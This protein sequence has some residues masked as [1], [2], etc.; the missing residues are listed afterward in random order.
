M[1][2]VIQQ[3]D[4]RFEKAV[5]ARRAIEIDWLLDIA[6]YS[7]KQYTEWD[8]KKGLQEIP[9]RK[10]REN[11]PRPV[12]NRLYSLVMDVYAAA[13][14]HEPEVEVLPQNSDAMNVADAKVQQAFLDHLTGPTQ[15]NWPTRRDRA[16][17]WVALL[18]EG[19]L[20]WTFD[21]DLKRPT[22]Q[23]CSPLE[24]YTD[25]AE[26]Y[27]DSRWIIH[28]RSMD[29]EDVYEVYG[30]DLPPDALGTSATHNAILREVG[31]DTSTPQVLVKE[32]WELP[33][34]RYANGRFCV[35]AGG[36]MLDA[37]GFPYDHKLLPFTQI[38]HSPIPGTARYHSGT[39]IARPIQMELNQYHAQKITSRQKFANFKWFID[40][41]QAESMGG[42]LPDDSE[43]QV[44]VGDSRNGALK[45]EILQAQIW[46]DS[47]DGEW[48]ESSFQNAVGLHEASMGQAPGRVDSAQGLEQLQEADRGRLA[49]VEGTL[50]LAI[51][52]G[53]AMVL[54]LAKQFMH[55]EQIVPDYSSEGGPAVHHMMTSSI[56][57]KPM[58]RV[59]AGGGLPKN[60]AAKRAEIIASWTAGLLGA[61]PGKALKML[62][63]PTDM[64]LTGVEQDER[65]AWAENLLMLRGIPVTAKKWQNHEVHR[66]VHDECRKTAEYA[67]A[68]E[69]VHAK[70]EFHL[71]D[72]LTAELEELQ[73]EANRQAR[74]QAIAQTAVDTQMP[75]DAVPSGDTAPPPGAP[76]AA[77]P[78]GQAPQT[79]APT[80]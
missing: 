21:D 35:W 36:E 2:P 20:K 55:E 50:T 54:T 64:N 15:A 62:D 70:F 9:R 8:Q 33:S 29:P 49:E 7:G 37:S 42:V 17:F 60:R 72:T 10:G 28:A 63:Y 41:A 11:A 39:R 73:E 30:K 3:L 16:L 32:M 26:H 22:I 19:W 56:P 57:D 18:G 45:P 40:S 51:G 14:A 52:R 44:L 61:D 4:R 27:V 74:I 78:Q 47:N 69:D 46:P 38:G 13:K 59:V 24:I 25:G 1:D 76:A 65:E 79:G 75:P 67:S 71:E 80:T 23:T 6:F 5:K 31:I 53:F 48:L 43:D 12:D 68:V 77:Q 58:V 34:R 66:R